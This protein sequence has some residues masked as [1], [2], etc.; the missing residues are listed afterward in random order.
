MHEILISSV[1]SSAAEQAAWWSHCASC[2]T[3]TEGAANQ[4]ETRVVSLSLLMC[5]SSLGNVNVMVRGNR[6]RDVTLSAFTV[7]HPVVPRL[8]RYLFRHNFL[9]FLRFHRNFSL[10]SSLPRTPS[11]IWPNER[12]TLMRRALTRNG[13]SLRKT[14]KQSSR[15]NLFKHPKI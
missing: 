15:F 6:E 2:C 1:G 10:S 3:G 5:V 11:W 4:L 14:W 8:L 9:I 13:R 12:A 7:L